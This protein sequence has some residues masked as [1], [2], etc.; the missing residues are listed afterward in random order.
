MTPVLLLTARNTIEDRVSRFDTG[1]DHFLTNPFAFAELLARV[2]SLLRRGGAQQPTRLRAAHLQLD[3]ASR[4]VSRAGKDLLLT[5]KEC[6][7][8]EFLLQNKNRVLTR[9][10]IIE[11]VWDLLY[12]PVTN[13]VYA[14]IR[15][16][17]A[18]IDREFS[19]PLILTVR[20]AG[21]MLER[22]KPVK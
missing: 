14:H 21:Y 22:P 19:P 12:D 20:G 18:N 16:L 5:N 6:A 10:E 11:H 2:L 1:A 3:P 4:R 8:V 9:T 7:V 17:R 15:A 13:I